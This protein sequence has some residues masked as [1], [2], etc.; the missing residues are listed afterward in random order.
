MEVTKTNHL[1]V[2]G[3]S[4]KYLDVPGISDQWYVNGL[5]HL[6]IGAITHLLQ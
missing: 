2:L 3:W 1:Q 4:S 6:H 5:F